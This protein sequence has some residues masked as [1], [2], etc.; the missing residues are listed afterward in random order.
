M[1]LTHTHVDHIWK[2]LHFSKNEFNWTIWTT[3]LNKDI[4]FTM[5]SDVI[6]LNSK[7]RISKVKILENKIVNLISTIDD[8]KIYW[9]EVVEQLENYIDD[10]KENL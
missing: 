4:L 1:L 7:N 5:L 10:L 6:K 3:K 9:N 8:L 2:M